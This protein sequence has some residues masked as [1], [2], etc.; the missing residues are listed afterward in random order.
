[1]KYFGIYQHLVEQGKPTNLLV[2]MQKAKNGLQAI[3][4]YLADN[5]KEDNRE[6][7]KGYLKAVETSK[8]HFSKDNNL[9]IAANK[10]RLGVWT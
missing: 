3:E 9:A 7:I 5:V 2:G 10:E 1:M 4:N 8:K 6:F